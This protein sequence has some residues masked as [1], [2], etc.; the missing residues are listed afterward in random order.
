MKQK[1]LR[2][3]RHSLAVI[4]PAPFTHAM[5]VKA[6]DTVDVH[7]F[8]ERGRVTMQFKGSVQLPLTLLNSPRNRKTKIV[9]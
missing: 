3:G 8:P 9:K 5:G 4:I 2:A 7:P 1:V 6:G